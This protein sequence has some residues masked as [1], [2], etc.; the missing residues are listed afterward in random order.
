MLVMLK[1]LL[2]ISNND[3]SEDE[4]LSMLLNMLTRKSLAYCNRTVLPPDMEDILIEMAAS[5]YK[6]QYCGGAST[7]N[8][9]ISTGN[10]IKSKTVGDIKID[11]D[12]TAQVS[13]S[14]ASPIQSVMD[15]YSV[16]LN[17]FRRPKLF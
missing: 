15:D 1:L 10:I 17:N 2:G 7:V 16:Q 8:S 13:Q 11:Y 14:T 5:L 12:T 4:I 6:R 3:T 9:V